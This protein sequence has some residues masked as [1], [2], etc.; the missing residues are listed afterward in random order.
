M[1]IDRRA[2]LLTSENF[3]YTG[4]PPSGMTGNRGWGV[5][6]DNSALAE[7]FSTVFMTDYNGKSI[8]GV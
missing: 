8:T 3:G 4:F 7:Y 2:I 5:Y 6:I 1:V